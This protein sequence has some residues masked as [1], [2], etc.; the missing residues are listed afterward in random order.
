MILVEKLH[1]LPPKCWMHSYN[2]KDICNYSLK[3]YL[4]KEQLPIPYHWH[5]NDMDIFDK[6]CY[7]E[8][9]QLGNHKPD[10]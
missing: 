7:G 8:I 9:P 5:D 3:D 6:A 4:H 1:K 2:I 10:E